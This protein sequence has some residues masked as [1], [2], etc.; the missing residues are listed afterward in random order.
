[1]ACKHTRRVQSRLMISAACKMYVSWS[2]L[3]CF[4]LFFR[5]FFLLIV[6]APLDLVSACESK[7]R[8]EFG[9]KSRAYFITL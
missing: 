4:K 6:L 3:L 5:H 1:M 7:E 2:I 9:K 8:K